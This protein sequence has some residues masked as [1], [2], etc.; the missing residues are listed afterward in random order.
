MAIAGTPRLIGT[1]ASVDAVASTQ[2]ID[3][4][5]LVFRRGERDLAQRML[6]TELA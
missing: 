1:F 4:T 6:D 5:V 3:R 2:E